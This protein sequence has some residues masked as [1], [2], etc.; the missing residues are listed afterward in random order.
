[1]DTSYT[2]SPLGHQVEQSKVYTASLLFPIPRWDGREML[3]IEDPERLPFHGVDV[4]NLYEVSWLDGQGK[5]VVAVAQFTVPANSQY[6][7]ESKSLKLYLNSLNFTRFEHRT[8]F[9][10]RVETDLANVIHA[11]V[12]LT[13]QLPE[14]LVNTTLGELPGKCLDTQALEF[15]ED[16]A[17]VLNPLHLQAD[18]GHIVDE[19]LY[20]DLLRSTC[21]VTGQPDWA[22]VLIR[23]RGP[24]INHTGLLRYIVSFRDH[25]G[26]HEQCVERQ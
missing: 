18:N 1:M 4:W 5:P 3:D 19:E 9:I 8:E 6:I 13:L 7:V 15:E 23:Y 14:H 26:F 24:A 17:F 12:Q 22:S 25:A 21:P 20:S 11:P 10:Q 2:D 16:K